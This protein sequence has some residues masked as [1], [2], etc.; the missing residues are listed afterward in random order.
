MKWASWRRK[1][2]GGFSYDFLGGGDTAA[3]GDLEAKALTKR[4]TTTEAAWIVPHVGH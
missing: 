1:E 4:S 3:S 2:K